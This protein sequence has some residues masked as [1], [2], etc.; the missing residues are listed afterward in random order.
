MRGQS[1]NGLRIRQLYLKVGPMH[2]SVFFLPCKDRFTPKTPQ[3]HDEN[4]KL[5]IK[6]TVH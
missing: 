4:H 5:H 3:L 6:F 2:S 1:Q